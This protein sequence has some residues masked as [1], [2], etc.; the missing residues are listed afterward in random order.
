MKSKTVLSI[1]LW[2]LIVFLSAFYF[3]NQEKQ[4]R[5]DSITA[6][7]SSAFLVEQ[8]RFFFQSQLKEFK[9]KMDESG[10]DP[11]DVSFYNSLK[12]NAE[13]TD[14]LYKTNNYEWKYLKNHLR[15]SSYAS[16]KSLRT[17]EFLNYKNENSLLI[18]DLRKLSLNRIFNTAQ[19]LEFNRFSW[20]DMTFART[21]MNFLPLRSRFVIQYYNEPETQT[22]KIYQNNKPVENLYFDI[23][24]DTLINFDIQTEYYLRDTIRNKKSYQL[25][26]K[27]GQRHDFEI[28]EIKQKINN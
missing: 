1:S 26:I 5:K 8:S 24:K 16:V 10:K 6:K 17:E 15:D 2:L 25:N 11:R 12:S 22:S 7:K 27:T 4:E 18:E 19:N 14:S 9:N 28:N 20:M 3:F 13:F 23:E 21:G